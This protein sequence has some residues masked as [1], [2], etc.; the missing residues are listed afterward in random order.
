M[1][2]SPDDLK[3]LYMFLKSTGEGNLNR[4]LVD[5]KFP[6]GHFNMLMKVVRGCADQQFVQHATEGNFPKIK[7]SAQE[8]PLKEVFWELFFKQAETRGLISKSAPAKAA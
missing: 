3:S 2:Y 1:P 8:I 7:L 5:Q 4:M 6:A